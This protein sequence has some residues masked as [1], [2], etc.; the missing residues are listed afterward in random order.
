M[1]FIYHLI[2]WV[3]SSSLNYFS[4]ANWHNNMSSYNT[5]EVT[6]KEG[7]DYL[8]QKTCWREESLSVVTQPKR[9]K[10]LDNK[11]YTY[12]LSRKLPRQS[13]TKKIKQYHVG[14]TKAMMPSAKNLC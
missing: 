3:F 9:Q 11:N 2:A 5:N 6:S 10:D 7:K 13:I 8:E 4:R 12:V 1:E 14:V